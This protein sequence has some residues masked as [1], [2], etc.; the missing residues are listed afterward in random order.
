MTIFFLHGLGS[1]PGGI[2]PAF[3]AQHGHSVMNPKLPDDDFDEVVRIAQDESD[4]HRSDVV[5]G[6]GRGGTGTMNI[7]SGTGVRDNGIE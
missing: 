1:T 7:N 4:R 3:L 6:S 5:V 2:Q